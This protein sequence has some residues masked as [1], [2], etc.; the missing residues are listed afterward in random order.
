MVSVE[1]TWNTDTETHA[2]SKKKSGEKPVKEA[3]AGSM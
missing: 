3:H 2:R 1:R